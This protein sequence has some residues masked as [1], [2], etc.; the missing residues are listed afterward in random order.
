MYICELY[1]CKSFI[2]YATKGYY[3]S[4]T[5]TAYRTAPKIKRKKDDKK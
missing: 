4:T 1:Y 5:Y 3:S 2:I